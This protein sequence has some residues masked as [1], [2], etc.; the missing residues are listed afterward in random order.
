[1]IPSYTLTCRVHGA[2]YALTSDQSIGR[3][4]L[5]NDSKPLSIR[6]IDC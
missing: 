1:M 5:G 3:G 6:E 4:S 2:L